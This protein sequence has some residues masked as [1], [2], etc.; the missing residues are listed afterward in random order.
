[1]KFKEPL[2]IHSYQCILSLCLFYQ[3]FIL[4]LIC[5]YCM[6]K[7]VYSKFK[8]ITDLENI[9][10]KI[11]HFSDFQGFVQ[12]LYMCTEADVVIHH[13][14]HSPEKRMSVLAL[15]SYSPSGFMSSDMG[16][17]SAPRVTSADG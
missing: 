12:T 6:L 5:M 11:K 4:T 13:L 1:M 2:Y 7:G 10:G 17:Q 16:F 14:A 8:P 15:S 3:L 9:G